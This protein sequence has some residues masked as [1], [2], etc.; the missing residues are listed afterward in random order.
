[1]NV[2]AAHIA[3]VKD[4]IAFQDRMARKYEG[5]E[6][7]RDLHLNNLRRMQELLE[8]LLASQKREEEESRDALTP[9]PSYKN[10]MVT[11]EDL[12]GLPEDLIKEL[13]I[14]RL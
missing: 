14:S 7:R 1:M 12:D 13:N 9:E 3:F 6:W 5:Q 8:F 2:I 11:A 4:Q 10:M